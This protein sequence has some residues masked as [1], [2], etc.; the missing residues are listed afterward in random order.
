MKGEDGNEVQFPSSAVLSVQV[1]AS[2]GTPFLGK[3]AEVRWGVS[4]EAIAQVDAQG[5]L[6]A[7]ATGSTMV[8][9][10]SV[11]KAAVQ[12]TASVTVLDAGQ[13]DVVVK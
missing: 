6:S 7:V 11:S 13:A 9:A 3:A 5:R 10:T 8:V 4:D 2:N 12:A 1:L